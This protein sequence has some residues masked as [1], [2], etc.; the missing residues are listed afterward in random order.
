MKTNHTIEPLEARIAPATLDV[1]GGALT[2]TAANGVANAL[3]LAISG[4]NYSLNDTGETIALTAAATTAGFTGGGSNT[5]TGPNTAV[6]SFNILLGDQDDS[7][8]ING[9]TDPLTAN[10][11]SG[12]DTM[13]V[14]GAINVGGALTLISKTLTINAAI[15]GAT[16]AQLA[17]DTM[18]I[19]A[20]VTASTSVTLQQ[21]T[22]TRD[23]D[24]GTKSAGVLGL[25]DTELDRFTTPLLRVGVHAGVFDIVVSTA[26]SPANAGSLKLIANG[27]VTATG[28]GAITVGAL[29]FDTTGTVTLGGANNVTTLAA[30]VTNSGANFSFTDATGLQIGAV[31]GITGISVSGANA[32]DVI[33]LQTGALTQAAGANITGPQLVL[34]GAGPV[35]LTNSGNDVASIAA[36]VT[37]A[38]SYTDIDTTNVDIV[39]GTAGVRTVNSPIV[40]TVLGNSGLIVKN[41]AAVNDVDAGTSTVTFSTGAANQDALLT[42]NAGSVIRGTGGVTLIADN[43]NLGGMVDAGTSTVTLKPFEISTSITLGGADAAS[44]LGLTDAE[45]DQITAGTLSILTGGP[46]DLTVS[47][48]VSPAN[49]ADLSLTSNTMT[50]NA[51]VA[52]SGNVTLAPFSAGRN[53]SVGTKSAGNL[54]VTDAE[55]DQISAAIIRIGSATAGDLTVSAAINTANTSTLALLSGGNIVATAGTITETNLRLEA[56]GAATFS[57]TNSVGKL[58]AVIGGDFTFFNGTTALTIGNVDGDAGVSSGLGAIELRADTLNVQENVIG[59]GGLVTLAQFTLSRAISLGAETAGQLSLTDAEIDLVFADVLRIGRADGGSITVTGSVSPAATKT[60]SLL[61]SVITGSGTIQVA[62]LRV[63]ASG[64]ISLSSSSDVDQLSLITSAGSNI[65]FTD[66]DGFTIGTVDGG[67]G[68]SVPAGGAISLSAGPVTQAAGAS[69][70]GGTLT[71]LGAGPFTLG[72]SANSI[73]TLSSFAAGAVRYTNAGD[74]VLTPQNITTLLELTTPGAVT[75]TG[76]LFGAG[77]LTFDGPGTLTLSMANNHQGGT[78]LNG[79]TLAGSGSVNSALTVNGGTLAPGTSPGTFTANGPFALGSTGTFA[80][81]LNGLTPGTLHDQLAVT[82]A[83][84]LAG[85]LQVSAGFAAADQDKFVVLANDGSDAISGTFAGLPEGAIVS[86]GSRFFKISYTGGTGND[87]ELTALVPTVTLGKGGKSVTFTDADGD[88]V[89]IKTSVGAF[90]GTEFQLIPGGGAIGGNTLAELDLGVGFKGAGITISAK[91]SKTS[92][93]GIANVGYVNAVGVDLGAVTIA[94][95][96]GRIDAGAVKSLTVGSLGALDTSTQLAGGSLVSHLTGKLGALTVKSDIRGASVLGSTSIGTVKVSGSFVGGQLSAGAD[97]GA[98]SVRG[99]IVGT[100]AAPVVIS[101]FGK[102]VAPTKGT[103]LAI[104]SLNVTGGVNFLR[105]LGGFDLALVGQNADAA[106]GAITVGTDWRA[107]TVLAGAKAGTDGF[108]GT[109]DDTKLTGGTVRDTVGIF[110]QIASLTI[111]GQAFG[112]T[113]LGDSFG[114]VAELI[115]KAKIGKATLKLDKGERDLADKFELAA[116]GPG[117]APDN[118]VSD[119][120]LREIVV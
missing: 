21:L 116:T 30:A 37:G 56:P 24:L 107:S 17:A 14:G 19:N 95:D 70:S 29:A 42:L 115:G 105:V 71:L 43:M 103:D 2:Y 36:N 84:S 112:T 44:T 23:I 33:S 50:I 53:I 63:Q 65:S 8:T 46:G 11:G 83:V 3:T 104:K 18:A 101:G 67:S 119:F 16:T 22:A 90:T 49:A 58:A 78:T 41:T 120:F 10:A 91:P 48:P 55:L 82:G 93:N 92:G 32:A 27:G 25:T 54:S 81:E 79:G 106:I 15:S 34:L 5:V 39:A 88:L 40:I 60:L 89:T 31:D 114:V 99:D 9:L 113:A 86:A 6:S 94:G 26:I 28:A 35:T 68:L 61:S 87:V 13:T 85:K 109:A 118:A 64:A 73:A 45:L 1:T 47:A 4:A 108:E 96:L 57:A 66:V 77:A 74:L 52:V 72:D 75:Q 69:I 98:V 100:A 59:G 110:S 102:A 97:L 62:N 38:L 117:P 111:K 20:A 80:I 12:A 7:F 76:L 51:T